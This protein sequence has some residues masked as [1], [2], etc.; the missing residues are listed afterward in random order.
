SAVEQRFRKPQALGSN[1]SGGSK[2]RH[3]MTPDVYVHVEGVI[4]L[5]TFAN[6]DLLTDHLP[7]NPGRL[8]QPFLKPEGRGF[9]EAGC[10]V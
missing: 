1:P 7:A 5:R 2:I 6:Q 8:C 10:G 9:L 3:K 4:V